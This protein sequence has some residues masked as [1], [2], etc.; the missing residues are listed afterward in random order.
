MSADAYE[1]ILM[2]PAWDEPGGNGKGADDH[3][4]TDSRE[5]L[6]HSIVRS[7][8]FRPAENCHLYCCTTMKSLPDGLWLVGALGFRYVTHAVWI[9]SNDPTEQDPEPRPEFGIGQYFRGSHELIL[10]GVRGSGFAVR[11]DLKNIPSVIYGRPQRGSDGQRIHSRKPES[12]Y[13]LVERRTSGRRLEM[14]S[15][16]AR[17]GWDGHGNQYPANVADFG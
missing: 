11:S 17:P 9:K 10:F 13:T 6:L 8:E 14:F 12:L 2:D 16:V 15:R 7:P 4:D 3:Y 5:S 1:A